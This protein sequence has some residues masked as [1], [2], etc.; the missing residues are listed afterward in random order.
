[1][2]QKPKAFQA[3]WILLALLFASAC[4]APEAAPTA[5]TPLPTTAPQPPA[6]ITGDGFTPDPAL[7]FPLA[8]PG[9]Y[10]VGKRTFSFED[11]SR[12]NRRIS[13]T[14]SYPAVLPEGST[15]DKLIGRRQPRP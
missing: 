7:P 9:P 8:E 1:M 14:L 12:D 6:E 13:I 11:A 3:I 5:A 2:N 15:G 4:G 10:Y